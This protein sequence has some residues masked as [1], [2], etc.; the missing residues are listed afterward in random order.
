MTPIARH[1]VSNNAVLPPQ[2]SP[3]QAR[4]ST[5]QPT[6]RL[7]NER[8]GL[9]DSTTG[10]STAPDDPSTTLRTRATF[11]LDDSGGNLSEHEAYPHRSP[12]L[13][14]A[15]TQQALTRANTVP[16]NVS[17]LGRAIKDEPLTHEWVQGFC[18]FWYT[19]LTLYTPIWGYFNSITISS[20]VDPWV[21]LFLLYV[22]FM[23]R[24]VIQ[25]VQQFRLI[26][27]EGQRRTRKA[28]QSS[29]RDITNAPGVRMQNL[30]PAES[31]HR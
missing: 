12:T 15:D 29:P 28:V 20:P 11:R 23:V 21:P 19:I 16:T 22:L 10:M 8:Q 17:R 6:D 25:F 4:V 18:L 31:E 26:R 14:G 13:D 27:R 2:T 24:V 1:Q 7:R 3:L 30:P 9:Q 5:S